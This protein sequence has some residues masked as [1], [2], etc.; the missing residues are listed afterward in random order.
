MTGVLIWE[1]IF[2]I[3]S[4]SVLF[5]FGFFDSVSVN[6]QVAFKYTQYLWL[7]ILL[8][9]ILG[10][11]TFNL[12][13]TNSLVKQVAPNVQKYLLLPVSTFHSFLRY[14]FF[15]NAFIFLIFTMAQ[16]IYGNKKVDNK[17]KSLELTVALD[18]S[19]SMNTKDIDNDFSRLEIAKRAL[20][21]LVNSLHGEKLG[22][23]VFAGGAYVQL[24]LTNDYH[25]AKMFIN[26]IES[27]MISNQ[28]TNI[29][30]ALKTSVSMFSEAKTTKGIILVTDGENHE[31]SPNEIL[32]TIL[33][34]NIQL[35]ILGI[36]SL[37]GG[38][39]PLN[40][41]RPELGYK[42][43][44]NGVQIHSKVDHQFINEIASK[45]HG[46]S[47]VCSDA[48]PNLTNLLTQINH[49]KRTKIDDLELNVKENR[50]QIPLILALIFWILFCVWS[51]NS[52]KWIDKFADVK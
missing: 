39:I 51:R 42:R 27:S 35:C 46:Y 49:M 22:I 32:Q 48:F 33:D 44:E 24:P 14:F 34:G 28:G 7:N 17:V 15:R 1:F 36:G 23:S 6:D 4:L 52:F 43:D 40:P 50:Y 37:K 8:I 45:A 31:E 12:Y 13:R 47:T 41:D 11:Y 5:L 2:W 9:P 38:L 21:Q 16:P 3:I 29:A 10:L 20:I 18:I 30:Q 19:N 26:E 25:A